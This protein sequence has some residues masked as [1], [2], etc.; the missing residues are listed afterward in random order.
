MSRKHKAEKNTVSSILCQQHETHHD[1]SI[2]MTSTDNKKYFFGPAFREYLQ[3][4]NRIFF[5]SF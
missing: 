1:R 2:L 4:T 3:E 5:L